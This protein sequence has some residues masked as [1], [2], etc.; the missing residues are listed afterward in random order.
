MTNSKYSLLAGLLN[1]KFPV[2]ETSDQ[3]T[4][5]SPS[6]S[7]KAANSTNCKKEPG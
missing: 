6:Q 7:V 4:S 1:Q 3:L 2:P 5:F